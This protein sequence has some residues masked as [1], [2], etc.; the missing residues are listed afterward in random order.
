M[1][2]GVSGQ[3][4]RIVQIQF[5]HYIGTVFFDRFDA[6]MQHVRYFFILI[7]FSQQFQDLSFTLGDRVS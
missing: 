4:G 5:P 6:D 1:L 7:A 2:D 3:G